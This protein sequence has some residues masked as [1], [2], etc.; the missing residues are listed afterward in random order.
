M[1]VETGG[2]PPGDVTV[3]AAT[4]GN[5]QVSLSWTNPGSPDLTG[6]MVRRSTT[7]SPASETVGVLVYDNLGESFT[8]TGRS[9]GIE[10]FYTAFAHDA[11]PNYAPGGLAAQAGGLMKNER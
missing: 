6:V 4:P 5:G 3:F 11:F 9:N 1:A 2:T 8:D 10:Y 7:A